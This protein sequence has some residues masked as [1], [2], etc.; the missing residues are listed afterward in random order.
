MIESQDKDGLTVLVAVNQAHSGFR[1]STEA[2]RLICERKGIPL[3]FYPEDSLGEGYNHYVGPNGES[4]EQVYGRRD[5]DL[6]AVIR[7]LGPERA[8]I[9]GTALRIISLRIEI[10]IA[11]DNGYDRVHAYGHG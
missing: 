5:P 2:A 1:L 8:G 7:E 11:D 3:H 6:I 10:E 4:I 9:R